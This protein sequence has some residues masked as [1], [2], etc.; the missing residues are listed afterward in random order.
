[1]NYYAICDL[2]NLSKY[3]QTITL[4]LINHYHYK[5]QGIKIRICIIS[6]IKVFERIM[7]FVFSIVFLLVTYFLAA[8]G[9]IQ[10]FIP[11]GHK[12]I[13]EKDGKTREIIQYGKILGISF[14]IASV[15]SGLMFYFFIYPNYQFL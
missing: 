10:G 3:E 12:I 8:L 1:M 7:S 14:I 13:R 9:L 6:I 5:I 2:S 15:L 4:R 11:G